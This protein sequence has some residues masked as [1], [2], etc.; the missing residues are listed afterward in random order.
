VRGHRVIRGVA[1]VLPAAVPHSDE[2]DKEIFCRA[3][4]DKMLQKSSAALRYDYRFTDERFPAALRT[5][6]L[7][8]SSAND[9]D[10]ADDVR[11]SCKAWA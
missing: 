1:L 5:A 8:S 4:L 10:E 7:A 3:A 11:L 2:S 6:L 9:M